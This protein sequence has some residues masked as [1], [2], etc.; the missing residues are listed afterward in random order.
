[1]SDLGAGGD[2]EIHEFWGVQPVMR[3]EDDLDVEGYIDPEIESGTPGE[4]PLK[5]PPGF[6][7]CNFDVNDPAIL[8]EV[9][10]FLYYNYGESEN[11][12]FRFDYSAEMLKWN[13]T[14]PGSVPDWIFGV[15][16]KTNAIVGIITAVAVD[17][18]CGTEISKWVAVNYLCVHAKLRSKKLAP[19]L[20]KELVRRVRVTKISFKAIFSGESIPSK[21]IATI[22]YAHRPINVKKVSSSGFDPIPKDKMPAANKRYAPPQLVH[23]NCRPMNESDVPAV[24]EFLNRYNEKYQFTMYFTEERVHHLFLGRDSIVSS[25]VIY[26][27]EKIRGFFSCFWINWSILAPNSLNLTTLKAT[28]LWYHAA[29][30]IDLKSLVAD[31]INKMA[32]EGSDIINSWYSAGLNDALIANKFDEGT[33]PL[34]FYAYNYT[35]HSV[36]PEEF[37]FYFN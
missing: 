36:Q 7:W 37:N 8:N 33:R 4:N 3:E 12:S 20:I 16:S 13:L 26:T 5:L 15:R 27:G 2:T 19:V 28:Y 25:Y 29:E 1:M 32:S 34:S 6:T 35:A 23:N 10:K 17:I 18:R 31:C 22:P 9:Y 21:P 24:T 30:G 11:H 14:Q